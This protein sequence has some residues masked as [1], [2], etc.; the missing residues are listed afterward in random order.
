MIYSVYVHMCA[1]CLLNKLSVEG[2][3]L[4]VQT[5]T[6]SKN[7]TIFGC[8]KVLILLKAPLATCTCKMYVH[9]I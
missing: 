8:L 7:D 5:S 9:D 4:P 1:T 3:G 6:P 2:N